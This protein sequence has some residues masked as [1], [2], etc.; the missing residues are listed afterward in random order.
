MV[1]TD[2]LASQQA[3]VY[4]G[5]RAISL[6]VSELSGAGPTAENPEGSLAACMSLATEGGSIH[7]R[8]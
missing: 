6:M 3:Q 2:P 5:R 7:P 4:S 8:K 1:R